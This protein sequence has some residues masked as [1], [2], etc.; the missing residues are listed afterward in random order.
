[1]GGAFAAFLNPMMAIFALVGPLM[2]LA[3]W[4]E[5][6]TGHR[7]RRA[8]EVAGLR[9]DTHLLRGP[10]RSAAAFESDRIRATHPDPAEIVER[11]TSGHSSLWERRRG[12]DDFLVLSV[13]LG[14]LRWEPAIEPGGV[15][16]MTPEI[17]RVIEECS[18]IPL[19]P[20]TIRLE[21]GSGAGVVGT[22][23]SVLRV[24]IGL[25]AQAVVLHGPADIW[26]TLIVAPDRVER[27][28]WLKWLPH[29][30]P[31]AVSDHR[32]KTD[33]RARTR[34]GRLDRVRRQD[35]SAPT[36]RTGRWTSSLSIS[37][38]HSPKRRGAP[39]H[40]SRRCSS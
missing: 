27:W 17:A 31:G 12:H 20:I 19:V 35:L 13:G 39:S 16:P 33:R 7:R 14:W 9:S 5:D 40:L 38:G 18:Q 21:P 6:R 3:Q 29:L 32:R 28:D 26:L 22:G 34:F 1:M 23:T 24:G 4:T 11:A 10:A 25:V 30:H 36:S 8:A 15:G 2:L 37:P